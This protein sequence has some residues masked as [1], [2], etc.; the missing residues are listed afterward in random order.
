MRKYLAEII[1]TFLLTFAVI[2]SLAGAAPLATPIAAA[3]AVGVGVYM[4]GSL[5]GAHF[6]PA[7]TLGV[8]AIRKISVK[9]AVL[10]ITAQLIGAGAATI[11]A[12]RLVQMP[13]LTVSNDP[14]VMMMELIG[15]FILA[16]G[17][18]AAVHGK[19]SQ[20]ASGITVGGSLLLG[21]IIAAAGSNGVLNP[22]VA[23]GIGS[24]SYAYLLGPVVGGALGMVLYSNLH[25]N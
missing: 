8:L 25:K 20:G 3:L 1:G 19:V 22:A 18:G 23:L 16:L 5:S 11:L 2:L 10:Y 6:N 4:F 12:R 9:D 13:E 7:I 21:I 14:D 24:F 17:V 15:A